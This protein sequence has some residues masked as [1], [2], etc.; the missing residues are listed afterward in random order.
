MVLGKDMVEARMMCRIL[1]L[2]RI[3]SGIRIPWNFIAFES[4]FVGMMNLMYAALDDVIEFGI[5]IEFPEAR[6]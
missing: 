2:S 6:L 5:S 4:S 3:F 1:T